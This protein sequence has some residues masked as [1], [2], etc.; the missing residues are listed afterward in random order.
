MWRSI[1]PY[2]VLALIG[3]VSISLLVMLFSIF[4]AFVLKNLPDRLPGRRRSVYVWAFN[5]LVLITALV[6]SGFVMIPRT[7]KLDLSRARP[8]PVRPVLDR[9]SAGRLWTQLVG[10][11]VPVPADITVPPPI[12]IEPTATPIRTAPRVP[13]PPRP[14]PPVVKKTTPPAA[15]PRPVVGWIELLAGAVP[16]TPESMVA[17]APPPSPSPRAPA[18]PPSAPAPAP[19]PVPLPSTDPRPAP[20]KVPPPQ[21][22]PS[23]TVGPGST[24][25]SVGPAKPE[26]KP[27]AMAPRPPASPAPAPARPVVKPPPRQTPKRCWAL[28]TDSFR[29][30][31]R[32]VY[33]L[34]RRRKL[35]LRPHPIARV[36]VRGKWWYRVIVGCF[37]TRLAA[38]RYARRLHKNGITQYQPGVMLM[39]N[40]K[41]RGG[42]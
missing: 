39:P 7:N 37:S 10:G 9:P 6:A 1:L 14:T 27:A 26:P 8:V 36:K 35:G 24:P 17:T 38:L 19:A 11:F 15:A 33:T 22:A 28:R 13:V 34:R 42:L 2:V 20:I 12:R 16:K 5:S 32:A 31:D 29:S 21:P 3:L 23:P 41:P 30:R 4:R 18:S 40:A 25:P